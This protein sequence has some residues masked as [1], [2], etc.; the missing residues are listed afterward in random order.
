MKKITIVFN[1]DFLEFKKGQKK[2]ISCDVNK[3]PLEQRFR[4]L[5]KDSE[6]D[7][8]VSVVKPE[9]KVKPA[10]P[11]KSTKSSQSSEGIEN[12]KD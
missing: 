7:N 12:V 1:Q 2:V 3:T 9:K 11:A 8:T 6:I 5:L 10:K 4:K